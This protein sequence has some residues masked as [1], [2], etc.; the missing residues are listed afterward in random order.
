MRAS[1]VNIFNKR[2]HNTLQ[3]LHHLVLYILF[4]A[5]ASKLH[6]TM[7]RRDSEDGTRHMAAQQENQSPVLQ[8]DDLSSMTRRSPDA[9]SA[10][11][12]P[13]AS[14]S[15]TNISEL[16][17]AAYAKHQ[18]ETP[19]AGSTFDAAAYANHRLETPAAGSNLSVRQP[20][21]QRCIPD[22]PPHA[23]GAPGACS[24]PRQ[25]GLMM[26]RM[27]RESGNTAVQNT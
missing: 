21:M 16:D 6:D 19:A 4:T 9:R 15:G 20:T 8:V 5:G 22:Q 18:L 24:P 14:P 7:A 10:S 13:P 17:T 27:I 26:I 11:R 25:G 12:L 2:T 3:A 1:R 23:T